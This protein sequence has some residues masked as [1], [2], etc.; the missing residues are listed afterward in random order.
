M[1]CSSGENGATAA[2]S[3][4]AGSNAR[5]S[6]KSWKK[7]YK[8]DCDTSSNSFDGIKLKICHATIFI[9][10]SLINQCTFK[11]FRIISNSSIQSLKLFLLSPGPGKRKQWGIFSFYIF[12]PFFIFCF[13]YSNPFC[14]GALNGSG[15]C[16]TVIE[17]LLPNSPVGSCGILPAGGSTC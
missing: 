16:R 9:F 14:L 15:W 6:C 8:L 17:F 10:S 3:L 1:F 4:H 7:M 5:S 12:W 11:C 2:F 13:N